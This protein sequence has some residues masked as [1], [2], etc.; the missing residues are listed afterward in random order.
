MGS[1]GRGQG[2]T[3]LIPPEISFEDGGVI[4][5]LK[6]CWSAVRNFGCRPGAEALVYGD[7]PAAQALTRFLKLEGAAFV[8][9]VGHRPDRLNWPYQEHS[10]HDELV[11]AILDDRIDPKDYYSHVMPMDDVA[12]AVEMVRSREAYKVVLKI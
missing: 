10:T 12:R 8:A 3:R 9:C 5:V 7:G 4:L 2:A 1:R 6:E 11:R